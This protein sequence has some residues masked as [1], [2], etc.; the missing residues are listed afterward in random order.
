MYHVFVNFNYRIIKSPLDIA[1]YFLTLQLNYVN[2]QFIPDLA[3][4]VGYIYR[5]KLLS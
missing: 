1:S 4:D 5:Y 3:N 2:I